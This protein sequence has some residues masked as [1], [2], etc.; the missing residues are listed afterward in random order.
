M[1]ED[2]PTFAGFCSTWRASEG[3]RGGLRMQGHE[4]LEVARALRPTPSRSTYACRTS[5]AGCCSISSSTAR[6]TRHI[7]VHVD[8]RP[9]RGAPRSGE[10]RLC[11]AAQAGHAA[12]ESCS[13]LNQLAGFLEKRVRQLL[14]VED[15]AVQRESIVD[16]DRQRRC[17]HHG[18]RKRRGRARPGARA[19]LRLRGDRPTAA[20]ASRASS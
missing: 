7:P 5:T 14:V 19:Q 10:W 9:R 11:R 16:P 17:R 20:R 12:K 3:F 18:R 4:A 2:D 1:V 6:D 8:Q 15:D 13:A